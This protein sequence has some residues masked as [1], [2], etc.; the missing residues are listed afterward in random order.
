MDP[1]DNAD[2]GRGLFT[3]LPRP[4][5]TGVEGVL[6]GLRGDSSTG[7]PQRAKDFPARSTGPRQRQGDTPPARRPNRISRS[8][9]Y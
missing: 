6:A 3:G 4:V 7:G 1:Q 8:R 2:H 5:D 9:S